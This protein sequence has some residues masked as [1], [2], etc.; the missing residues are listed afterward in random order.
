MREESLLHY[1]AE[2]LL[3]W[4]LTDQFSEHLLIGH[5]GQKMTHSSII[6]WRR[7]NFEHF[8]QK[9]QVKSKAKELKGTTFG[10]NLLMHPASSSLSF[11]LPL[12]LAVY[13]VPN[14]NKEVEGGVAGKKKRK[15]AWGMFLT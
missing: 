8:Q 10:L 4:R 14:K 15:H 11:S 9:E 5:I 1:G 12:S 2:K 7:Q 6:P 13:V 3:T